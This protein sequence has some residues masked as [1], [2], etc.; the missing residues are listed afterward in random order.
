MKDPGGSSLE[1]RLARIEDGLRNAKMRL[2]ALEE[3]GESA[4]G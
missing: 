2:E 4:R 1:E 3:K